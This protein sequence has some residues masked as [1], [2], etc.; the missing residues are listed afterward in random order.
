[1]HQPLLRGEGGWEREQGGGGKRGR[2]RGREKSNAGPMKSRVG[3][4]ERGEGREIRE[5]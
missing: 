3:D 4:G 5:R 1:M 2:E